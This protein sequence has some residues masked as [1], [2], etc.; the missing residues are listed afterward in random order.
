MPKVKPSV[1]LQLKTLVEKYGKDMFSTD[2]EILFCKMC[3]KAIN[4]ETKYKISQH[5][6]S[7]KHQELAKIKQ[8]STQ[9]FFKSSLEVSSR[10]QFNMDLCNAMVLANI[11]LYKLKNEVF[12]QFL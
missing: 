5:L 7:A 3:N 2:S 11:P 10:S 8:K 1:S 9:N 12:K 4:F 6:S